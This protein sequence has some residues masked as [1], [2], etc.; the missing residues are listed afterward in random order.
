MKRDKEDSTWTLMCPHKCPGLH[1]AYGD[2][3]EKLYTKYEQEGRG[4]KTIEVPKSY[5]GL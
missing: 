4:N 5:F 1:D 2:E 3:F